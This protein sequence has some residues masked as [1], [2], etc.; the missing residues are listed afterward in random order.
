MAIGEMCRAVVSVFSFVVAAF[1]NNSWNLSSYQGGL[2]IHDIVSMQ[3][4][5]QLGTAHVLR[6]KRCF[7]KQRVGA[8]ILSTNI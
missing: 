7:S 5:T 2:P 1:S 3:V 4:V 8:N 6:K